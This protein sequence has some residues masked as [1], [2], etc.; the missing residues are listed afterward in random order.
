MTRWFAPMVG[1]DS[2]CMHDTP[3]TAF[4][5]RGE[6]PTTSLDAPWTRSPRP[7]IARRPSRV[8]RG[9]LFACVQCSAV[10]AAGKGHGLAPSP[11]SAPVAVCSCSVCPTTRLQVPKYAC[12]LTY[13]QACL[14]RPTHPHPR[15]DT[16]FHSALC[17]WT[18][19][20]H[21]EPATVLTATSFWLQPTH[22][23]V[24]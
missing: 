8:C 23:P 11:P 1:R 16:T 13:T 5:G 18:R 19:Q 9:S 12:L 2:Y 17:A 21:A 14:P 7:R 4:E 22:R 24:E 6:S 20:K 10:V 3:P 15:L